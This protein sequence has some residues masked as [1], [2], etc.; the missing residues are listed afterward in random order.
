MHRSIARPFFAKDRIKDFEIIDKYTMKAIEKMKQRFG[1]GYALN[2]EVGRPRDCFPKNL[3]E[4]TRTQDVIYRFT[5]DAACEFLFETT[6]QTLDS[7]LLYPR[8]QPRSGERTSAKELT[9]EEAFSQALLGARIVLSD[10]LYMGPPWPVLEFFKDR[11]EPHMEVIYRFLN[12]ILEEGLA[13]HAART[14]AGLTDRES[15]TLLD[16]LLRETTGMVT[17]KVVS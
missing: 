8:T 13:K 1:E 11:T 10:R 6:L 16:S 4:H 3:M 15:E 14:K 2:F 17:S 7:E 9:R 12:P 5:L